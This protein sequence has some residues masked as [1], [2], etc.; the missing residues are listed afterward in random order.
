V[1]PSD[2][3]LAHIGG[4]DTLARALLAA[5]QIISA[6]QL[7]RLQQERYQGWGSELGRRIEKGEFKLAEL[8]DHA[9]A[10]NLDPRP[11]SGHQ[12][13]AEN[14]VARHCRY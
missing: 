6:G 2:L 7:Q 13:Q 11:R 3:Y 10:S 9:L 12:E 8:A 5:A 1:D 14:I 4:I